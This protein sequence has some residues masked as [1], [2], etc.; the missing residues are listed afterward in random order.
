[1][2]ILECKGLTKTFGG[3]PALDHV[4]LSIEPG[5]IIGLLGPNGSGK[6]T[7]FK[8]ANGLLTPT[9]GTVTVSGFA[10]GPQSKALVSYLPERMALADWMTAKQALDYYQDFFADFRREQAEAMIR[11]LGL[12]P[13][14][15]IKTMSK[16]TKEK[17][18]LILT[19]SREARL[20]LLDE[21]IGGVDPATRD[22]ILRTIIGSY[23]E[24]AS[25][26]I[27]TH[28]IADVEQVLDEVIFLQNGRIAL[29]SSV[30]AIR[31][32][33]GTSVDALFREVFRC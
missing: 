20:Y 13:N 23:N 17:L 14:Q 18:Q 19:M 29:H 1:M 30:D 8:L 22:Y 31:N 2:S 4:D 25:I 10:P 28:L 33:K 21:P 15:R 12:Q 26:I 24:N 7:L 32:E 9:A 16:G 3:A 27:S 5:H 6:T 11:N